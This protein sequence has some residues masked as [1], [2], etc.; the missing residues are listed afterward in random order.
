MV[1]IEELASLD[2]QLWLRSGEEAAN[3]LHCAQST[4]SRRNIETLRR[5]NISM[6]RAD[7]E[8]RLFGNKAFLNLERQIHQLHRLRHQSQPLRLEAN[9]W[10]TPTLASPAPEHWM[11]G[12]GDHIGMERP[13]QLVR[14]RII[15][16]WIGSYQPDLP[17]NDPDLAVI[18][19]C[20]TPVYLVA[21]KNH[22]LAGQQKLSA[23]DLEAFPS[24]SIPGKIFPKTE[25]ILKSHKLWNNAARMKCFKPSAWQG[26]TEDQVTLCYA[27][28]LGLEVMPDLVI[29][30]Y[31]LKLVSAESLVV[32]RDILEQPMIKKLF[33]CL[34]K[35]VYR[36]AKRHGHRLTPL[37]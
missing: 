1:S 8:W 5:F 36:K 37:I 24:L 2:L 32:R 30:D 10:A 14:E 35:R 25:R 31:D 16:A 11:L 34:Q 29:L 28:C 6:K 18:D 17:N 12:V 21:N 15:D 22:P 3:R 13:L 20:S 19:L 4:I 26:Q 23:K 33:Q 7:G 27:T 9:F